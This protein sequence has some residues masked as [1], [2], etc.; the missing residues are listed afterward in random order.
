[1]MREQ[2]LQKVVS[3]TVRDIYSRPA[4][5]LVGYSVDAGG[6]LRTVGIDHGGAIFKEYPADQVIFD[7][8]AVILVPR[9]RSDVERLSKLRATVQKRAQALEQLRGENQVPEHVYMTLKAQLGE[10]A[11][12][13][14]SNYDSMRDTLERRSAD[15]Q[16]RRGALEQFIAAIMVQHRSGEIDDGAYESARRSVEE[17]LG[18]D[19]REQADLRNALRLLTSSDEALAPGA[20]SATGLQ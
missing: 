13:L 14:Q 15:L 12:R 19:D 7:N 10:D 9:W 2:V 20:K 16:T 6:G 11:S 5:H 3:R 18:Q 8:E 4:G 1:M 17:M